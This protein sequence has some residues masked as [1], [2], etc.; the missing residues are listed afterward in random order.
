MEHY[1][2]SA[3]SD[4]IDRVRADMDDVSRREEV[5]RGVQAQREQARQAQYQ[6]DAKRFLVLD[7][8]NARRCHLPVS[9]L[10]LCLRRH[11]PPSA[12]PWATGRR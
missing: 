11:C 6:Q 12:G 8:K 4:K 10:S 3:E 1:S 9:A 2:S 5:R 7:N